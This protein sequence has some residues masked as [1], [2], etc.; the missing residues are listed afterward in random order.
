MVQGKSIGG[1]KKVAAKIG[2][3][4]A[5]KGN[6]TP[7]SEKVISKTLWV[8]EKRTHGLELRKGDA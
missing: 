3:K 4:K 6:W 2:V 8:R 7:Q 5:V 1:S